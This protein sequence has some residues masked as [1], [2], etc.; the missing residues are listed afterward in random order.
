MI[1]DNV[2]DFCDSAG[3]L[4]A[5]L[6]SDLETKKVHR[7]SLVLFRELSGF[8]DSLVV[9]YLTKRKDFAVLVE[10]NK[11]EGLNL[12]SVCEQ[13]T[14]TL[15]EDL[16]SVMFGDADEYGHEVDVIENLRDFHVAEASEISENVLL[17]VFEFQAEVSFTYFLGKSEYAAMSDEDAMG[18]AIIDGDWNEHVMQVET[19]TTLRFKCRFTFNS[20]VREVE[21]FEVEGI[22][23]VNN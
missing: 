8:T 11:V 16:P 7:D 6:K 14:D 18:F 12:E 5:D 3:E 20:E 15:I 10:T 23:S 19:V 22:E 1:T 4:H 2:R 17:V 21:S 9:P 13:Y